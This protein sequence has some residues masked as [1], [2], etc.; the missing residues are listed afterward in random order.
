MVHS[1][2]LRLPALKLRLGLSRSSIYKHIESGTFPRPVKLGPRAV[3]WLD[4][5][6]NT[7]L[8]ARIAGRS[9]A[10]IRELVITLEA[11]RRDAGGAAA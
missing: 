1:T 7:L 3:G 5:E 2:M 11:A 9:E 4:V 8:A 10:E 6:I